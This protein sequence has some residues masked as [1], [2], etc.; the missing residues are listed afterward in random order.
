[1]AALCSYLLYVRYSG[2]VLAC[3]SGG[4]EAVQRSSYSKLAGVPVAALG[5]A[6]YLGVL[7]AS[8]SRAEIAPLG[9]VTIALAG[10]AVASYLLYPQLAVR[11][12]VCD[13]CLASD[14]LVTAL[15]GLTVVRLG[16]IAHQ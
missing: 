8:V 14:A 2:A 16:K 4:C 3:S 5:L 7:A 10:M 6:A 13:W 1:G 15:A 12:A 9:G 11:H